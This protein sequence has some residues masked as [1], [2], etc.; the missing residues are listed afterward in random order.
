MKLDKFTIKDISRILVPIGTFFLLS[1]GTTVI[2]E[3]AI[4]VFLNR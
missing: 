2:F 3:S 1:L 4:A